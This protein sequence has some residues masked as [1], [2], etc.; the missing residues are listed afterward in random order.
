MLIYL[1]QAID[2]NPT[3]GLTRR[4]RII[5]EIAE[6]WPRGDASSLIFFS[7]ADAFRSKGEVTNHEAQQIEK[8]NS[9]ALLS[10]DVMVILYTPGVESWGVPM[11]LAAFR[12]AGRPA[13]LLA[14]ITDGY[15][16]LPL[17]IR[18]RIPEDR[19]LTSAE[20]LSHKLAEFI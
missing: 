8:I 15:Y 7:P 11:E 12:A 16:G 5:R 20:I 1:A 9:L 4:S 13:F 18:T 10:S 17:Y 2:K 14:N 19:V 6:E 3:D